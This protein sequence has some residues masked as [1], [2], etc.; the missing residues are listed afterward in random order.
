MKKSSFRK[1]NFH[2]QST[3]ADQYIFVESSS[4]TKFRLKLNK[5]L[6]NQFQSTDVIHGAMINQLVEEL[7][8]FRE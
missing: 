1:L 8:I 5:F 2:F 3:K 4:Y 7:P 6:R